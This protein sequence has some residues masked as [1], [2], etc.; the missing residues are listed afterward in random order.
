MAI[1]NLPNGQDTTIATYITAAAAGDTLV[2]PAGSWTWNTGI[3]INKSLIL[4]GT[5][6]A[7]PLSP[8]QGPGTSSSI[9]T[10]GTLSGNTPLITVQPPSNVP[11]RV[12]GFR[13]DNGLGTTTPSANNV[14]I[15]IVGPGSGAA[16]NQMRVDNCYFN[17][18]CQALWWIAGVYGVCDHC[19]F[20]NIWICVLLN[21]GNNG[22]LG[23]SA[24]ARA[25]YAAGG[26]NFPYTEDCIFVWNLSGSP[27]SPWVTYHDMAGRSVFRHNTINAVSAPN[28][29]TGPCDFHG[30]QSYWST[31]N[32][33]TGHNYR[34]TIR[35]EF[36]NNTVHLGNNIYQ[37]F[38]GR[39]GSALIHDNTFT[40]NDLATPNIVD[41]R[42][43]E[44]DPANTPGIP[45]RSPVQWPCEDQ[46]TASFIWN[47]TLNGT[48]TNTVG[49]GT[50]G[51]SNAST[52]DPFYIHAN[53]DYWQS[54]PGA[55]TTTVYPAPGAPSSAS[56]PSPYASLQLT[57][58]TP[59]T[60]PHPLAIPD[61]G[62]T[63]GGGGG[64]GGSLIGPYNC[65]GGGFN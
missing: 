29:I 53:R 64:V 3:T 39:G 1:T 45:V 59:Y 5:S 43:E 55:G 62:P 41:F 51:N 58:Y 47:N 32:Q 6:T 7:A 65:W 27:G 4:R 10:R 15:A 19:Y 23:D 49:I 36:Y 35:F 56:Y 46:I 34:G 50:F 60:Y 9:I 54:A 48:P 12:T 28:G 33:A 30:N 40:T 57:S 13:L 11:I 63:G 17:T 8:G 21:G 25:D 38:D 44:D 52:G 2:V 37:F 22:D 61:A 24:W 14:S 26:P 31:A 20:N 42:D 16:Y 18:G